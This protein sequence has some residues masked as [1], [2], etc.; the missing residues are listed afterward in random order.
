MIKPLNHIDLFAGMGG[1]SEGFIR[2]VFLKIA[3]KKQF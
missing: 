1:L 2:T 3:F